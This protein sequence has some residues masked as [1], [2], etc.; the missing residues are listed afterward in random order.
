MEEWLEESDGRAPEKQG[1]YVLKVKSSAQGLKD[2]VSLLTLWG[3]WSL[4]LGFTPFP[5]SMTAERAGQT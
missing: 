3:I 1:K 2:V 5:R 4:Q